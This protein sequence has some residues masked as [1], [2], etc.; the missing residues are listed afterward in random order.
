MLKIHYIYVARSEA[1]PGMLK[2]GF[3]QDPSVRIASANT[4]NAPLPF[5]I[6]AMTPTLC[7]NRD[8][9]LIHQNFAKV[10]LE[11]EFFQVD[12]IS[13]LLFFQAKIMPTFA[14]EYKE[15]QG[16][17]KAGSYLRCSAGDR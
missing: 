17:G 14:K 10:R 8:E 2:I 9:T 4:F 16:K 5:H 15:I 13:V 1:Y 12:E 3:S 11:G 7:P 6:V